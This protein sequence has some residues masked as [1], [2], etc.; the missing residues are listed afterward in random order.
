MPKSIAKSCP[1]CLSVND[2]S[3]ML[4]VMMAHSTPP[5]SA[6]MYL[7]RLCVIQIMKSTLESDVVDPREVFGDDAASSS[8]DRAADS[9]PASDPAV[10]AVVLQDQRHGEATPIDGLESEVPAGGADR[11]GEDSKGQLSAALMDCDYCHVVHADDELFIWSPPNGDNLRLCGDC[12]DQ[13]ER[14]L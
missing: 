4:P 13:A 11:G 3:D 7:C 5:Q 2:P 8:T 1:L 10:A 9:G 6:P 12:L 14:E